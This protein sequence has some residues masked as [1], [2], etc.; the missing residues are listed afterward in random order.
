LGLLT[1]KNRL[2]Y[3]LYC[4]GWDVKH[5]TIQSNTPWL[6]LRGRLRGTRIELL[7][8]VCPVADGSHRSVTCY[9]TTTFAQAEG[10]VE[11]INWYVWEAFIV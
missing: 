7:G 5:C 2:P 8:Q 9:C 4:V 10:Y 1:C 3:N 6:L 11:G